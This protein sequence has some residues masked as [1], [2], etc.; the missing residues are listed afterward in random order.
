MSLGRALVVATRPS[1]LARWQGEAVRRALAGRGHTV[2]S[3]LCVIQTEGDRSLAQPLPEIGGKGLFTVE[4][5][6]ALRRGEVDLAVHS[7]KDLPI[8]NPA[9]LCLAAILERNDPRD[10]LVSP[11]GTDLAGLPARAVVGSSSLR[12]QAQLLAMRP[13]LRVES[14]R[15]NVETRVSKVDDGCYHAAMMAAAG[16]IRLGLSGRISEWFSPETV[17][18]APGQGALAVQCREDDERTKAVLSE[19]DSR[20]TRLAVEAERAFL[21]GLGGGCSA[22]VGAYGQLEGGR[23]HLRGLVASIDGTQ[24]VR[25]EG[26]GRSPQELGRRL[27]EEA[28]GQGA[29]ELLAHA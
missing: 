11:D 28:I 22:P 7:L 6:Q 4:L 29:G 26:G 5:E 27:A 19:I 1:A 3:N 8:E 25:V 2:E 18:P 24:I 16:L 17:L 9:G 12:R 21:D 13:D 15:G 20:E 14:I 23:I 10:V